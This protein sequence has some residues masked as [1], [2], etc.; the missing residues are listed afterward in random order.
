MFRKTK[1]KT[2]NYNFHLKIRKMHTNLDIWRARSYLSCLWNNKKDKIKREGLYQD[3]HEGELRMVDTEVM[4]KAL[5]LAWIPRLLSSG[6]PKWKTVLDY[7]LKGVGGL[8]FSLRFNYDEKYLT[9]LP[10]CYGNNLKYFRELKALYN[11]NQDQNIILHNNKDI[12]VG[13]EPFFFY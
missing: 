8:N 6:S 5:K 11:H 12:L 9:S 13:Y 7:Y 1:G 3:I 4:F 2:M 10:V